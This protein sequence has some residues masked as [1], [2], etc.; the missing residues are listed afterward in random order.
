MTGMFATA[1]AIAAKPTA[2]AKK[3]KL[4]IEV[5]GLADL[6]KLDA[7]IKA[8]TAMKAT[9]ETEIKTFGF[10]QF[11][12]MAGGTRPSS[13]EGTD[14]V[15]TASVELR[16]RGTN[17]ALN[18]EEVAALQ[19]AGITP[20]KQIVTNGLFAINPKYAEDATLLGKVEKSLAKI[21]PEDFIV[22][23][24]EV[25]K[26]VVSDEILDEA[27][28]TAK[29]APVLAIMTTMALKPKLSDAYDMKQLLDDAKAIMFPE[30]KA[31][32]ALPKSKK[33]A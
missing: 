16:K 24:D 12:E 31:K 3:D 25:S 10:D 4:Q 33:A 32:V 13:F 5:S 1:K 17:S 11:M 2:K 7:L 14:G 20:F 9:L 27:F 23:Q 6:A 22:R 19:A 28:R 30:A 18:E 29:P 15:A 8:A 21:V 26:L